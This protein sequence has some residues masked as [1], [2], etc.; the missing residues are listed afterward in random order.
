[1]S[2]DED[3][4]YDEI[5]VKEINHLYELRHACNVLGRNHVAKELCVSMDRLV[6]L[7][8]SEVH[9]S[10]E[11]GRFLWVSNDEFVKA[12]DECERE[13]LDRQQRIQ[14]VHEKNRQLIYDL[15]RKREEFAGI[16]TNKAKR[17]LN[18]LALTDMLAKA[19]RL[20]LE[21][22]DKS[23]SAK[24]CYGKYQE[25]IYKQKTKLILD[26]CE[27][28]KRQGWTYGVQKS[29]VPPT[30]HVIYFEISGCEQISWHFTPE[31]K[32]GSFPEY[33]GEW[34]KKP[35][36]TLEK[37]EIVAAKLLEEKK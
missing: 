30:S 12:V 32:D 36:S 13:T 15:K 23:I 9:G 10:K 31:R 33:S 20:A 35:N 11:L 26:L 1:M 7:C 28:F 4:D 3:F 25:K 5:D 27:I 6:T 24:N 14:E 21:I 34:D 18:K 22:E 19:V 16:G 29:N 37:L 17:R 8:D 2:W